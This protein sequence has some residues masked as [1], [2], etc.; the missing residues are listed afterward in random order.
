MGKKEPEGL[1]K[2]DKSN[3]EKLQLIEFGS[4]ITIIITFYTTTLTFSTQILEGKN[5]FTYSFPLVSNLFIVFLV[6]S[7]FICIY[8]KLGKMQTLI[9]ILILI[10][11]MYLFYSVKCFSREYGLPLHSIELSYP[12]KVKAGSTF[13]LYIYLKTY[14]GRGCNSTI[15]I[16]NNALEPLSGEI[17]ISEKGYLTP[18]MPPLTGVGEATAPAF[19]AQIKVGNNIEDGTYCETVKLIEVPCYEVC[20]CYKEACENKI[21]HGAEKLFCI[22]VINNN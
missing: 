8:Y 10:L 17:K 14:G 3:R 13:P 7:A 19:R 11:G 4:I 16:S 2:N 1:E 6:I 15:I 5:S 18:F 22:E 20:E 21:L 9:V 12:Q